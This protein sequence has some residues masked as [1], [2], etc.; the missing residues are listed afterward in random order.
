MN[1]KKKK[2]IRLSEIQV[3]ELKRKDLAKMGWLVMNKTEKEQLRKLKNINSFSLSGSNNE[4][5]N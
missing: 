3:L 4:G 5:I 2:E 1:S